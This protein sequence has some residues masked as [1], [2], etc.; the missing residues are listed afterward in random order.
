MA[1]CDVQVLLLQKFLHALMSV[2]EVRH[3]AAALSHVLAAD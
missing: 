2:N 1:C 3:V